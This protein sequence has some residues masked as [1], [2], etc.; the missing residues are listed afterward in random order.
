MSKIYMKRVFALL[1]LATVMMGCTS[2]S[3]VS[4]TEKPAVKIT[5]F[6]IVTLHLSGMRFT[7]EYEVVMQG[8]NA[9]VAK[10]EIRYEKEKGR[11]RVPVS[12]T[13]CSTDSVLKLLN[14]CEVAA[15][16]GFHGAHPKD[17]KDGIMFSLKAT[18]NGNKNIQAEGSENFPK[19]FKE[20]WH[21]LDAILRSKNG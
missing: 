18:V 13:V 21:G 7:H 17:V 12:N 14:D 2:V 1:V 15:W 19:H 8:K 3:Q 5:S 20:F 6:E 11:V 4:G 16:D 10:Y 9:E